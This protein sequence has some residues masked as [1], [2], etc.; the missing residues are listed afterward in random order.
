MILDSMRLVRRQSWRR[1][2]SNNSQSRFGKGNLLRR[3]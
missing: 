2:Q 1:K 3:R